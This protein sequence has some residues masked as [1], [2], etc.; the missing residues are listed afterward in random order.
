MSEIL[1]EIRGERTQEAM[2][3]LLGYKFNQWHKWESG[4]KA[5]MWENLLRV[6]EINSIDITE[7]VRLVSNPHKPLNFRGGQLLRTIIERYTK[8][9]ILFLEERLETSKSTLYRL[10]DKD[11]IEVAILLQCIGE[12]SYVLP[13]FV[14]CLTGENVKGELKDF[15]SQP[16]KYIHIEGSNPWLAAV[17]V[18]LQLDDYLKLEE[19]SDELISAKTGLDVQKV[20]EGIRSLLEE[21]AIRIEGKKY[22]SNVRNIDLGP[23]LR[24]SSLFMKYWTLQACKRFET[25]DGVP[26]SRK[27]WSCRVFA[28][29]DEAIE[30]VRAIHADFSAELSRIFIEDETR[31]KEN[32]EVVLLHHFNVLDAMVNSP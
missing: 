24:M 7:A 21:G 31:K 1:K 30:K 23:D 3:E 8:F 32:V 14:S 4:Q 6:A 28:A 26:L 15:I 29:S 2:S 16:K 5:F 22:A 10:F 20:R 25:I 18:S 17:E 27:G 19:H 12:L 13:Q 11:D 9:D